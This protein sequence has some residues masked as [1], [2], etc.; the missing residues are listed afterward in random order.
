MSWSMQDYIARGV[1]VVSRFMSS[2]EREQEEVIKWIFQDPK[3]NTN[4]VLFVE[5]HTF[6]YMIML[7]QI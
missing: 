1:G 5:N 2:P 7:M 6:I 4:L 3:D